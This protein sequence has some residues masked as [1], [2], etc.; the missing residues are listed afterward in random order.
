M[1]EGTKGADEEPVACH[2]GPWR[3]RGVMVGKLRWGEGFECIVFWLDLQLD[4]LRVSNLML[5]ELG[6]APGEK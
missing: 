2:L 6:M 3:R 4:P 5:R 1:G